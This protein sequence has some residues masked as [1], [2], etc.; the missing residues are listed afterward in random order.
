[1]Q[2]HIQT[3][4][5]WDA[6]KSNCD[7]AMCELE[8][9][10]NERLIRQYTDEAVM[11]PEFR[12]RVNRY[13]FCS[14]HSKMLF[15]GGNKLGV[16]LQ[17]MTRTEALEKKLPYLDKVKKA[18]GCAKDLE[19]EIKSCVICQSL[20]DSMERYAY[21]IGQM[22]LNE[23]EFPDLFEKCNG[24][25]MPHYLLLLQNAHK[26]GKGADMY[27]MSL[28]IVQKRALEK[29][30]NELEKFT[31]KFDYRSTNK[32]SSDGNDALPKA[33]NRLRGNILDIPK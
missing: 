13:G 30:C 25:C 18:K 8:K 33:I 17:M 15:N 19:N 32:S 31:S 16:A 20:D 4:P 1:M 9:R 27:S 29:A 21:T 7:C 24:F 14:T 6:F 26:A 22:Y 28:S 12:Q 2:Y 10:I 3:T 11:I 23:R 5:V